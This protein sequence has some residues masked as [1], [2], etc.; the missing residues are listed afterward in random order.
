MEQSL[1]LKD[2]ELAKIMNTD[3]GASLILRRQPQADVVTIAWTPTLANL[4]KTFD[5]PIAM[6]TALGQVL[7]VHLPPENPYRT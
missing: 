2:T 5:I 3:T 1:D 4:E 6:A 7:T